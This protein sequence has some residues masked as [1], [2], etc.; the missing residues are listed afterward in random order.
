MDSATL[1]R[2]ADSESGGADVLV[3]PSV[4]QSVPDKLL[5]SQPAA[6]RCSSGAATVLP[7]ADAAAGPQAEGCVPV[8][9]D[10]AAGDGTASLVT[11]PSLAEAQPA[12]HA[13]ANPVTVQQQQQQPSCSHQAD[14]QSPKLASVQKDTDQ[15][16]SRP[17]TAGSKKGSTSPFD[18]R[19]ALLHKGLPTHMPCPAPSRPPTRGHRPSTLPA[20]S[21]APGGFLSSATMPPSTATAEPPNTVTADASLLAEQLNGGTSPLEQS[22]GGSMAKPASSVKSGSL[23]QGATAAAVLGK[24]LGLTK[25]SSPTS[26]LPGGGLGDTTYTSFH[27]LA[28][29]YPELYKAAAEAGKAHKAS[30]R[31]LQSVVGETLKGNPDLW[32]QQLKSAYTVCNDRL[33]QDAVRHF[34]SWSDT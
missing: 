9:S 5:S 16:S 29:A 4:D 30:S 27:G 15:Q 8:V 21:T 13:T 18:R 12:D 25:P 1:S 2:L 22:G 23:Q 11:K 14:L 6:Q 7:G 17:S 10:K 3:V 32:K 28:D 31:A 33:K 19:L 34:A 24:D 20:P 26:V